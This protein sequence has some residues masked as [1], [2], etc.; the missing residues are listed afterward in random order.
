MQQP[1]R[2][3]LAAGS[4]AWVAHW[5]APSARNVSADQYSFKHAFLGRYVGALHSP[6]AH[7]VCAGVCMHRW[8]S[9]EGRR[10]GWSAL[11]DSDQNR[12]SWGQTTLLAAISFHTTIIWPAAVP[13]SAE[14]PMHCHRLP[15][16]LHLHHAILLSAPKRELA[17][18]QEW[19]G[20]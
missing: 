5:R 17:T 10:W 15:H 1:D 6:P 12:C 11:K 19:C 8:R 16:T 4:R 18:A 3:H 2:E 9:L 14:L 20:K 13:P 7:V